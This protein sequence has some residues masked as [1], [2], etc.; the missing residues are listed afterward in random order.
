M[1]SFCFQDSKHQLSCYECNRY[2]LL[3]Q[4]GRGEPLPLAQQRAS[5]VLPGGLQPC[6]VW[7]PPEPQVE[8]P[9]TA[10]RTTRSGLQGQQAPEGKALAKQ[11]FAGRGTSRALGT[12]SAGRSC[13]QARDAVR[14]CSPPAARVISAADTSRCPYLLLSCR[15]PGVSAEAGQREAARRAVAGSSCASTSRYCRGVSVLHITSSPASSPVPQLPRATSS[16]RKVETL[17]IAQK[18]LF[19]DPSAHLCVSQPDLLTS[20]GQ[21][22]VF[23]A[24][25]A[26][27]GR[28]KNLG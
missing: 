16:G 2:T 8:S 15:F 12:H 7:S 11:D 18:Q 14:T 10:I 22:W 21:T 13:E 1:N 23:S 20:R 25:E 27:A 4:Q 28:K 5:G 9:R 6:R 24:C 19:T 17:L 3:W 26:Q